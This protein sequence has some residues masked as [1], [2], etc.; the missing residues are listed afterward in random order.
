[1]EDELWTAV[2]EIPMNESQDALNKTKVV[3]SMCAR[4]LAD[5][6][7]RIMLRRGSKSNDAD[8]SVDCSDRMDSAPLLANL[9]SSADLE[10]EIA[11]L[12][13]R[14]HESSPRS[15][16]RMAVEERKAL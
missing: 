5:N 2:E 8:G 9:Q 16:E 1:M 11:D 13:T 7:E 4:R 12:L 10:A 14:R 3:C 6:E 15:K